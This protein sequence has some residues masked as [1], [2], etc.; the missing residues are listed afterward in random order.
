MIGTWFAAAIAALRRLYT[1]IS[2]IRTASND[3]RRERYRRAGLTA[4]VAFLSQA[5]TVLI[6]LVSIPLTIRYLGQER[7][8]VWLTLNSILTWLAMSDFGLTGNALVNV[9]GEA[10]GADDKIMAREYASSALCA[11][12]AIMLGMGLLFLFAFA[13]VPW[14]AVFHVSSGVSA[15]ELREACGLAL[16]IFLLCYPLN[17]LNSLYSAYQDGFVGN[18]WTI[19][20]NVLA[21]GALLAVTRMRGGLPSLVLAVS[22][23]R[24]LVGFANAYYVYFHRYTWLFPS[25]SAVRWKHI[26]RLFVLGGKYLVAQ[27]AA[28]GIGQSQPMIIT[29]TLGPAAVPMFIVP[30]RL[31]TL[32]QSLIFLAT[33]PLVS[34]YAEA[35]ARRDWG[36]IVGAFRRSMLAALAMGSALTVLAAA[37]AKPAIR[38]WVGS[39]TVPSNAVLI[40]LTVYSVLSI[41]AIPPGQ[42]LWGLERVGVQAAALAVCAVVTVQLGILFTRSWGLTG[43][44][45]SMNLSFLAT[46]CAAQVFELRRTLRH[47][48]AEAAL[49]PPDCTERIP[50]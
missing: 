8:G 5:L 6:S 45:V 1:A 12:I 36:W 14:Q 32:P 46:F 43:L 40:G 15:S 28:L 10:N 48:S 23:I 18:I 33:A 29:Q 27:L 13:R 39:G 42:M 16:L 19:C 9:L 47:Y 41:A 17:M 26:R 24:V 44:L 20:G 3:R 38:I 25:M 50:A 7:Y 30:Y 49:T 22:G 11:L 4:S 37:I 35:K 2:Q 34:A 31:V 21:L